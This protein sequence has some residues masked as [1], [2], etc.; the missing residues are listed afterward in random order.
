MIN[1]IVGTFSDN[2]PIKS[3][4][5]M[6]GVG[7]A[8][9]N[10]VEDMYRLGI[11]NVMF[12]VCNTD[13]LALNK[14][15]IPLKISLGEKLTAGLG[16]G[17][18]P[19]IGREAALESE[20]LIRKTLEETG[21][22]MAFIGAGMGGGT[23]T[24]AAPVIARICQEMG[25]LTVGFVTIPQKNEGPKRMKA[26]IEG[27]HSISENLDSILI[28]DNQAVVETYGELRMT[29]QFAKANEI[30]AQSA[31]GIAEIITVELDVNVDFADVTTVMKK[32]GIA[33]LGTATIE[34]TDHNN[35]VE[36]AM[37]EV[38]KSSLLMQTDI[39]GAK[40]VLVNISWGGQ[41]PKGQDIDRILQSIQ[42][43]AGGKEDADIIYGMGK[44]ISLG[45][46][47]LKVTVVA[48]RFETNKDK[49]GLFNKKHSDDTSQPP[50]TNIRP[51][52]PVPQT[53]VQTDPFSPPVKTSTPIV[54]N[55]RN[56]GRIKIKEEHIEQL[57]SYSISELEDKP[58]YIRY[59][60][61]VKHI[62]DKTSKKIVK[63]GEKI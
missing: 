18:N 9:C 52:R 61:S 51:E 24:G 40:D 41:E 46:R 16:A 53:V 31:K 5:M 43:E 36:K 22:K 17:A 26:A 38:L 48:T 35:Y 54:L 25:I 42:E 37:D 56:G 58:A 10:I 21:T 62:P 63:L 28:V 44:D 39:S 55:G 4:I 45:E 7:G 57:K 13:T 2:E 27:L 60:L 14:K 49:Y 47:E 12:M 11:H 59:K 8:G 33:L 6:I 15:S 19:S 1:D 30:L 34:I 32:S 23:G 29:M 3:N 50:T 20:D